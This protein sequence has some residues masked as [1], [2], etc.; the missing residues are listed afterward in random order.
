MSGL[1]SELGKKLAERWMTLLV[2]PGTLYVAIATIAVYLGQRRAL[3][4]GLLVR[5]I[6][7]TARSPTV[8]TA[9]GQ[10]ILLIA[11]LVGAAMVGLLIQ[12]M[13]TIT[14]R[15][16]LAADWEIWLRPLAALAGRA[17]R[18]RGRR[19]D[20][21]HLRHYDLDRRALA[22]N[23]QDRPP[24]LKLSRAARARSRIALER[25]RR[26]TWSGD[27]IHAAALRLYRDYHLDLATVWPFIWLVL[28]DRARE[29]VTQTR[30]SLTRAT[31]LS[32][33]SML[34]FP[35][36]IRWWP[37]FVIGAVLATASRTR[38]RATVDAYA[39][40]LEATTRL[41]ATTLAT[42]LGVAHAGSLTTELGAAL[43]RA[44]RRSSPPPP[45][46]TPPPDPVPP[47][48]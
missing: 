44:V 8:S 46:P 12:A 38:I 27:R 20:A 14:E 33:W 13:G 42:D 17:V 16:V 47:Q 2:L 48:S 39:A 28:P 40:I 26:P 34:Y 30:A 32:A 24:A 22:P 5:T 35:L 21:A 19:W 23:P 45:D 43:T 18:R 15:I 11:I 9:G 3:D 25:P 1:W 37:A 4:I 6:G 36:G 7:D 41:Y 29:E 31:N 10:A